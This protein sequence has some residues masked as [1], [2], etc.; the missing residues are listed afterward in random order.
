VQLS[1]PHSAAVSALDDAALATIPV[2]PSM[3]HS[4]AVR[5]SEL[6]KQALGQARQAH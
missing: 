4:A 5:A 2:Q 1:L 3:L 6:P